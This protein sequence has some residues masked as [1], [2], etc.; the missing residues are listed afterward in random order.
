MSTVALAQRLV[1]EFAALADDVVEAWLA[2][3]TMLLNVAAFGTS[4]PY[5]CA[6]YAGHLYLQ[7]IGGAA[8]S[9]A[10]PGPASALHDRNW[11][12]NFA[13]A[14]SSP[15]V[16]TDDLTET[17]PGRRYLEIRRGA[18]IGSGRVLS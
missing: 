15:T 1:P 7:S 8:G 3:A 18:G 5:A 2:D 6:Y 4:W 10:A 17:V 11:S 13:P 14:A 12:I 9:S 16:P